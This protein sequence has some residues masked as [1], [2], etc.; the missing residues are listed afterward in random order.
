MSSDWSAPVTS[1]FGGTGMRTRGAAA[2]RPAVVADYDDDKYAKKKPLNATPSP[3]FGTPGV[4]SS[5]ITK[6]DDSGYGA[7][8]QYDYGDS[9]AA[10]SAY[11]H[12]QQQQQQGGEYDYG[13]GQQQQQQSYTGYSAQQDQYASG[14]GGAY[15]G[16]QGYGAAPPA[17]GYGYDDSGFDAIALGSPSKETSRI[18]GTSEEVDSFLLKGSNARFLQGAGGMAAAGMLVIYMLVGWE[19]WPLCFVWGT[20][21]MG[22][23]YAAMLA[24]KILSG[25][26]GDQAMQDVAG[27]IREAAEGFLAIQY[28]AILK[29]ALLA[30][31]SLFFAY[32][33]RERTPGVS[34]PSWVLAWMT[35]LSFVFGAGCS[36][37]AGYI[38]VWISVRS[39]LRVAAQAVNGSIDGALKMAFHGGAF[40]AIISASMCMMGLALLYAMFYAVSV[41]QYGL[42]ITDVPLMLAGYGFGAS[43]VAL[44]M[45]VAGGIYTKAADV[46]ADMVGKVDH[47]IPEDDPK[48]PA[49]IAD[50]VGDN[51]GDCAGSMADVFESIAA[52]I[53]GTMILAGALA[54]ESRLNTADAQGYIFFPLVI[55][56]LDVAVSSAGI[57]I[58]K[59]KSSDPSPL[60]AMKRGYL[61]TAGLATVAFTAV[62]YCMLNTASAPDAWF[63]YWLCGML[64]IATAFV[65]LFVCQYYTD[66]AYKPVRDIAQ[67][68]VTG[69]GTNVIQGLAIG[70][71]S[72]GPPAVIISMALAMSYYLGEGALPGAPVTSGLFGNAV[73]T[74]GIL[75]TAVFILSMNNFGPIADNAGGIVEMSGQSE[76]TRVTTDSLDAIGNVTKAAT[77]GYSVGGSAMAFFLLFRA[78]MDDVAAF[79]GE[80]FDVVNIAKIEVLIGGLLGV[81]MIFVFTGWTMK[82]V[83]VAAQS[84]VVEVRRQFNDLP[85]IMEGTQRPEYAQC[86][87]IVTRAALKEAAAP[88]ML[89]LLSPVCV[90][91]VFRVIGAYRGERLLAVSVLAGFMMFG[92]V[93]ALLL[94]AM[95]DNAGG[96]W[97]NAKKYIE[98]GNHGGKGS[99]AHKASVTGDTVGDPAKDTSGPSLH[100]VITTMST[101]ILVLCP[102]F[103]PG[104]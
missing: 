89:A 82:A 101:T 11:N 12:Q 103:I 53:L 23:G 78:F 66:Y 25:P 93:T 29:M 8:G 75:C 31:A 77:K 16:F 46:G 43:F 32:L 47:S 40:S 100:V 79:S 18:F 57:Y 52:E 80:T 54:T 95:L 41:W 98:A 99:D 42:P 83:G 22:L 73:A 26:R 6:A 104:K 60:S 5:P 17:G 70:F 10:Y 65:L 85:G 67:A 59:H 91:L 61:L 58:V 97:D 69:H 64:G 44:F 21:A 88:V 37:L 7:G 84:V 38:G 35:A 45:Q 9:G 30:T 33:M 2:Q 49:V 14:G 62:C 55:H 63:K 76:E 87:Q 4:S 72:T 81:S 51:V 39:N 48:N 28:G 74:M 68:S 1:D 56:A 96:A 92:S 34:L 50:L 36:A 3:V 24:R 102:I 20:C 19:G 86:T 71:E 27:A 15:E 90:G 94:A 13:H